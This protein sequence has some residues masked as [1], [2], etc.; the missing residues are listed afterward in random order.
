MGFANRRQKKTALGRRFFLP[1][2]LGA[3]MARSQGTLGVKGA[4]T[5]GTTGGNN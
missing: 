2:R 4:Y 1:F 5:G 3:D